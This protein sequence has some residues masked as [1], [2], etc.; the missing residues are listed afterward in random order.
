[1]DYSDILEEYFYGINHN[2]TIATK[3]DDSTYTVEITY[4]DE[5]IE[6][7]LGS[8]LKIVLMISDLTFIADE[9]SISFIP[10]LVR[11][12]IPGINIG[13]NYPNDPYMACSLL[14]EVAEVGYRLFYGIDLGREIWVS[15]A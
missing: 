10:T 9:N 7:Y 11:C 6:N 14:K 8:D 1:M 15:L 3:Y 13:S 12:T 4:G 2:D 5:E